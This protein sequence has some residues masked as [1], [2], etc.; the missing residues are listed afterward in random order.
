MKKLIYINRLLLVI[1]LGMLIG[2]V[3]SACNKQVLDLNFSFKYAQIKDVG[4]IEIASWRDYE[5]SDMIQVTGKDG[6]V[7]LTHSSNIILKSK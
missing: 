5:N 6:C 2:L 7:Y 1:I 4:T 3:I